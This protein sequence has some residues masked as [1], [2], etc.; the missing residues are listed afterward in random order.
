MPFVRPLGPDRVEKYLA[1]KALDARREHPP[2]RI[3]NASLPAGSPMYFYCRSCGAP[4]DEKP[5]D[6]VDEVR[7]LCPAC[8]H[9][10][11]MGWLE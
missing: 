5:E 3:D 2:E 7:R 11:D 6:Y 10:E 4:A 8:Q 1:L 9:M